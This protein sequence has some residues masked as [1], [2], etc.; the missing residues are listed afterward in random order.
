MRAIN[1]EPRPIQWTAEE[2]DEMRAL[3]WFAGQDVELISGEVFAREGPDTL[4]K[5]RWTRDELFQMLDHGLLAGHRVELIAGEVLEMPAQFNLHAAAIDLTADALRLVFGV[6]FWVRRQ[7]SLDLSPLGVPDPDVD[8]IRDTPRG[9]VRT[10]PTSALLV[11]EASDSTLR[12]DR[13]I[14]GSLYAAAGIADYWI[15][16]LVQRQLEV[17]RDPIPDPSAAFGATYS[18]Q[19]ILI[20]GDLVTPLAAPNARIPVADLL[21]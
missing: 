3:G 16:N 8:V 4:T 21:P 13:K 6:G 12:L 15:V 9:S 5:H 10:M 19:V 14:K 20:P 17:Y 18:N 11:V 1:E 7:G 2:F